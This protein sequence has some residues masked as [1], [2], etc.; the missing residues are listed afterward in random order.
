MHLERSDG[1]EKDITTDDLGIETRLVGL[2]KASIPG[3]QRKILVKKKNG[4][5]E[6]RVTSSNELSTHIA[7]LPNEDLDNL[8][9]LEYLSTLACR[10]LLPDDDIPG[11]ELGFLR[12]MDS[13]ALFV[14]RFDRYGVDKRRH[15]EEF[16]Q[17]LGKLSDQ[18][19]DASY[20]DMA[21][22]ILH[23]PR[24]NKG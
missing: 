2:T 3:M 7:K 20:G 13:K 11:M 16:T 4:S 23:H 19:Y 12:E 21:R 5:N 1:K 24:C 10:Y 17:I 8:L 6:Y 14:E 22:F 18:K 9:E 15:F